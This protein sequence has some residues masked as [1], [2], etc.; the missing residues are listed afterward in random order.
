MGQLSHL[1]QK[2]RTA[3]GLLEIALAGFEGSG[4]GALLVAEKLR[5]DRSLGNRRTVDG[6]IFIVFARRIGVNDLREKLLAHTA[7]ARDEHRQV[8]RGHTQGNLQRPVEERGGAD[9]A[10]AL[11]YGRDICHLFVLFGL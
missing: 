7:L 10:E 9:D 5:V 8:R 2:D 1:V 6:Y 4:K 11:F 3:V